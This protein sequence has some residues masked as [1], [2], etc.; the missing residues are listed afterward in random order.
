MKLSTSIGHFYLHNVYVPCDV[1]N[2]VYL[3]Q[4]NDVLS[5][6]SIHISSSDVKHCIVTGDLNTDFSPHNSGN[7]VSLNT[8]IDNEGLYSVIEQYK[9]E[10]KYTYSG[11]KKQYIINRSLSSVCKYCKFYQQL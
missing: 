10:I 4:Y 3:Q 11:I 7:T 1:S 5:H 9:Q 2:N 6:I 8:F